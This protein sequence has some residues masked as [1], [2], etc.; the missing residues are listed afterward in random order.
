MRFTFP[1]YGAPLEDGEAELSPES[2]V[3]KLELGN[4]VFPL[5]AIIHSFFTL[6]KV[7]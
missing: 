7:V 6:L 5:Q 1:P 4:E 2:I 3:P